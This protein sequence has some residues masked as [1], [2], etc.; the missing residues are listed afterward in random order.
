[1]A[2]RIRTAVFPI[3]G[4]GTRFLPATKAISKEMLPVVDRPLIEYAVSEAQSA[5][6][7]RFIFVVS[8]DNHLVATHFSTNPEL[9]RVLTEKQRPAELKS[10]QRNSLDPDKVFFI[11]QDQ[12]LGLGDAV[13][14]A[15]PL[16]DDDYFAVLLPD[17]LVL[18][19]VPCLKQMVNRHD[20]SGGSFVA[21]ETVNGDNISSYGV[22]SPVRV[23]GN[24]VEIDGIIE[25]PKPE[26]APS[27]LAVIGRYILS[28]R[29]FGH[30]EALHAGVGGEIQLTDA[31]KALLSEQPVR[32]LIF[33]GCRYDCGSKAG[34]IAANIAFAR[35]DRELMAKVNSLLG[36]EV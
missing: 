7:E 28:E 33:S 24:V 8:A 20:E 36:A 11:V 34:Y 16:I 35:E 32:A 21:V 14:R 19:D 23:E 18:A 6:I 22:V 13:L 5:G 2:R 1:M 12:P 15:K 9:E 3:A 17:D 27:D 31:I 10:V 30:L 29:V 26:D 4:L 25:K